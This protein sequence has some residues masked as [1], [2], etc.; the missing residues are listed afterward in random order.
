MYRA[1]LPRQASTPRGLLRPPTRVE[2]Q[3]EEALQQQK[4]VDTSRMSA[5]DRLRESSH[6]LRSQARPL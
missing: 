6:T 3:L 4:Y 2:M 1:L 5:P